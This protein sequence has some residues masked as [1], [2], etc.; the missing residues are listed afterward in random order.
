MVD[1][2]TFPTLNAFVNLDLPEST[3]QL[4]ANAIT[5]QHVKAE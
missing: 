2:L 1:V 3:V 4:T 5:I